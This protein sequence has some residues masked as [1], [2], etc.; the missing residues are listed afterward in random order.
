MDARLLRVARS[1]WRASTGTRRCSIC[2]WS[3]PV[4]SIALLDALWNGDVAA[5]DAI[6]ASSPGLVEQA[7]PNATRLVAD[8][9]RNN[10]TAAVEAMLARG[11]PVTATS[12]HG[13]MPQH[14]AAWH[15]NPDML[16]AVLSHNPPLDAGD[17]DHDGTAMGWLIHGAVGG[18]KGIATEKYDECAPL[19]LE[20]GLTVDEAALPTG[21]DALD[22]VLREW[23]VNR[24]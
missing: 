24:K 14:W 20:A 15:G 6:L 1:T 18:W 5:A 4:R 10:K 7:P 12:Q 17:R 23:L 9:A 19:L 16:R 8:A 21:H 3:G 13:A 11:F 2:C 22:R